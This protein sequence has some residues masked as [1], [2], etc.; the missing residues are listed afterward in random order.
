LIIIRV[1]GGK[2]AARCEGSSVGNCA[3]GLDILRAVL[4]AGLREAV[5]AD[6]VSLGSQVLKLLR[7]GRGARRIS[8]EHALAILQALHAAGVMCV[9]CAGPG[10][11]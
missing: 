1:G 4:A 9:G 2:C 10:A 7:A 5:G 3:D 6:G 8:A 11:R